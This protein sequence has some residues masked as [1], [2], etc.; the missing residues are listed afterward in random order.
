MSRLV[1]KISFNISQRCNVILKTVS[2]VDLFSVEFV[3]RLEF[4]KII[5]TEEKKIGTANYFKMLFQNNQRKWG[6]IQKLDTG[7]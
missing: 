7:R 1:V 3:V 4:K 6:S 5:R 2:K